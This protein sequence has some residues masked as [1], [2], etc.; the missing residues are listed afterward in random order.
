MQ[1]YQDSHLAHGCHWVQSARP[2]Q[3]ARPLGRIISRP[4]RIRC[5]KEP[6]PHPTPRST[7]LTPHPGA[8]PP[9]S[10]HPRLPSVP[11]S[12]S[13]PPPVPPLPSPPAPR[14]ALPSGDHLLQAGEALLEQS[15]YIATSSASPYRLAH[16]VRVTVGPAK[17]Y[18]AHLASVSL[19]RTPDKCDCRPS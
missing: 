3:S 14:P 16:L 15:L 7:P 1:L 11:Q 9:L 4:P 6:S 19:L 2:D 13:P 17:A 12:F 5:S 10:P 18:S 8:P